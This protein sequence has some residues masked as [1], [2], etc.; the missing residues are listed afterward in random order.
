MSKKTEQTININIPIE[1]WDDVEDLR[2][3]IKR[4][5]DDRKL[6]KKDFIVE[7]IK[8]GLDAARGNR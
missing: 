1:I 7:L 4:K 3:D 8:R 2:H 6:L 5:R